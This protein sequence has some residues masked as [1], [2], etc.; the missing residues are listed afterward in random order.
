MSEPLTGKIVIAT[1]N[2][3]KLAEMRD[4]LAPYGLETLS[5]AALGLP[6]PVENGT[7]Y[8]ENAAIKAHSAAKATGLPALSDDSGLAVDAL[9]GAP[10]LFTADWAGHPRDFGAAMARVAHELKSRDVEPEGAKA[11]FVS[12]LVLAWP[13]GETLIA[14]G[15]IFGSLTFPP[16]R[17]SRLWL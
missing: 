9:D 2:A 8:A 11:H 17:V 4:L 16:A 12:S 15:R 13:N 5:A 10:G 14:E 7:I 1:H 3:G 6:E